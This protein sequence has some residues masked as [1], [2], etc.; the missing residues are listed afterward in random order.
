MKKRFCAAIIP[1]LLIMSLFSAQAVDFSCSMPAVQGGRKEQLSL[2]VDENSQLY[3][4]EFVLTYDTDSF[5]YTG[6]FALGEACEGLSPYLNVTQTEKGKIKI[7][8]TATEPLTAGGALCTLEFRA[9]RH[10]GQGRFDLTAEHAETFDGKAIRRL[11][12]A[13]QGAQVTIE[14]SERNTL[15]FAVVGGAVLFVA[16][17]AVLLVVKKKRG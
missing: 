6:S 3:T 11:S 7:V 8:Y 9:S 5:R 12:A 17:G 1:V 16:L 14:K 4:A 13:A 10:A 15:V 2:C